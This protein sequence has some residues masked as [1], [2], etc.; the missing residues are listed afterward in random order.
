MHDVYA[1]GFTGLLHVSYARTYFTAQVSIM[2]TTAIFKT[3]KIVLFISFPF[4]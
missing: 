4:L 2:R 3:E 1:A